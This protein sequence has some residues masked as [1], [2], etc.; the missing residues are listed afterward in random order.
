MHFLRPMSEGVRDLCRD[1]YSWRVGIQHQPHQ[2]G[3]VRSRDPF[4]FY[5]YTKR[6][7]IRGYLV[8]FAR[9]S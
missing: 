1:L 6:I 2:A 8:E 7:P 4:V 5:S 9:C 3:P